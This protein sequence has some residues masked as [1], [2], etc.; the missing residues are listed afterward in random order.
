MVINGVTIMEPYLWIKSLQV[1]WRWGTCRFQL[2][3]SYLQMSCRSRLDYIRGNQDISPAMVT[4]QHASSQPVLLIT[5]SNITWYRLMTKAEQWSDLELAKDIPYQWVSAREM[6]SSALAIELRLSCTN[7]SIYT[8][9]S[10]VSCGLPFIIWE[11]LPC[12]RRTH[13]Y[14]LI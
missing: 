13:L 4:K 1:I 5:W 12:Y 8:L 9:V 10:Q 6:D 14:L 11:K 3:V 2:R 7:P